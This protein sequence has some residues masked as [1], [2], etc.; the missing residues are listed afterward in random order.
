[1]NT[2]IQD[3]RYGTR[4]LAKNPGFAAVAVLTLALGI[5]ANAAIFTVINSALLRKL[6]VRNPEELVILSAPDSHGMS[7]GSQ[8]D[9]RDLYTYAEFQAIAATNHV[10]TGVLAE[11]SGSLKLPVS[12]GGEGAGAGAPASIDLV[13]GSYF[14]VLGVNPVMGRMFGPE[15]DEKRDANPVAVISYGFWQRRFAGAASAVGSKIR[16]RNT[17]YNVVGVAPQHFLGTTV[18]FAPDVWVPLTMQSELYPGEDFLTVE[19]NP[20]EKTEWL[21]VIARRKPGVTVAQA[22]ADAELV[23]Q[24]YLQSQIGTGITNADIKSFLNQHVALTEGSHGGSVVHEEFGHPLLILMG[25]VGL[26]LVIA[27]A[28]VANL[29][30]ARAASRQKEI[31][32]RISLGAGRR[33]LFMQMLTESLLLA[34]MG[35][36]V[37]L[38][39]AQWADAL[40]L[41]MVSRQESPIPLDVHMD[42]K[43]LGFT[44]GVSLLTGLLFGV[45]PAVRASRMD[46][47]AVLKGN[48]R[49]VVGGAPARGAKVPLGKM[50]VVAQVAISLVLLIVAGLF[51]HSF[52]NL[53]RVQLGFDRDHLVLFDV[54]PL[55]AGYQPPAMLQLYKDLQA[56]IA[57][58]PGVRGVSFSHNGLFSSS[59]SGDEIKIDGYTPKAGQEMHARFD[60]VGP[61]YFSTVGIPVLMGRQ[62]GPEDEG[63]GQRVAVINETMAKYYFGDENPIGRRIWDTFPTTYTDFVVVG[64]VGDAKY[65]QVSEKTPRRFYVPVLQPIE[66]SEVRY[67]R[68]EVRAEGNPSTIASSLRDAVKQ[69]APTLPPIEIETMSGLVS[70]S[71]TSDRMITQLSEFFGALAALLACVGLYGIMAYAV[72]GRVNEIGI[73]M[74]LGAE[75]RNVRWMI[76]RESLVLVA[77][78]V[79]IGLPTVAGTSKLISSL[80]YGLT[81]ADPA[82]IAAATVLMFVVA[83]LAAYVPAWR[84]SRIDPL[85]AL[86]YE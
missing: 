51:V 28:N 18:G 20:V 78:G 32:V 26:V 31:A 1:M 22:K 55:D 57:A 5:G 71:L 53:T 64:V 73:R 9:N 56:R 21:Q 43:I 67:A 63:N 15:V 58:V 76:L 14:Q 16:I 83:G 37:G 68:F 47:N 8:T 29:L 80:L 69:A 11:Q 46:L 13:S 84:A 35:G 75:G 62:I 59:E 27:C 74:A 36:A 44:L 45:A 77:I 61:D 41:Q 34:G 66:M 33:R 40:L 81:P 7:I 12:L 30:L 25:V 42:W 70:K 17:S 49:G 52:V 86:R 79:V 54:S 6:P 38:L 4:M 23:F 65:N 82:A 60:H 24:Q 85:E 50:L 3:I 10:F 48:A 19:K 39:L 2:L 72:A